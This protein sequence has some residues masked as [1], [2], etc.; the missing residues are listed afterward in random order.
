MEMVVKPKEDH[1]HLRPRGIRAVGQAVG[2]Q[3]LR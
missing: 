1:T 2:W 3:V